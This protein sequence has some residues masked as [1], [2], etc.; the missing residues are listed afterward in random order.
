MQ[1]R[2]FS[3]ITVGNT[4]KGLE[5]L[6]ACTDIFSDLYACYFSLQS[7]SFY[8]NCYFADTMKCKAIKD[9]K[10]W[11]ISSYKKMHDSYTHGTSTKIKLRGRL[12]HNHGFKW[13]FYMILMIKG[14]NEQFDSCIWLSEYVTFVLCI[15][16]F[17]IFYW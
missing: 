7:K 3:K 11:T 5:P 16:Y 9:N 13:W 1:I 10:N 6:L 8:Y 14:P 17:D 12:L 2:E 15:L 4:R